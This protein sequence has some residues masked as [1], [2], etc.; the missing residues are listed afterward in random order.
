MQC[1]P[2][3]VG[4]ESLTSGQACSQAPWGAMRGL[5]R[6]GL[7]CAA[8]FWR[9]YHRYHRPSSKKKMEKWMGRPSIR[10]LLSPILATTTKRTLLQLMHTRIC[11]QT[12]PPKKPRSREIEPHASK[13]LYQ[14][15][16]SPRKTRP[17]PTTSACMDGRVV[18]ILLQERNPIAWYST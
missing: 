6:V 16:H 18:G 12:R 10:S 8:C 15:S 17:N 4:S 14:N 5:Q 2:C 11:S 9:P 1:Q 7:H 3:P 13:N